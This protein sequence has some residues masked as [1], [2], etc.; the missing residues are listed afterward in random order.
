MRKVLQQLF[1]PHTLMCTV[2]LALLWVIDASATAVI[3][4]SCRKAGRKEERENRQHTKKQVSFGVGKIRTSSQT[5]VTLRW[6][7]FCSDE[8]F[9][10]VALR[11]NE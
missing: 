5:K 2:S 7:Q 9:W 10:I 6:D 3:S 4:L 11:S 1:N 8:M